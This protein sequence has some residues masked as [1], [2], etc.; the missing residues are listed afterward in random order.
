[1]NVL[2]WTTKHGP[3]PQ[4]VSCGHHAG[5][6]VLLTDADKGRERLALQV[7]CFKAE[8]DLMPVAPTADL[9]FLQ[10]QRLAEDVDLQE[11]MRRLSGMG[12]LTVSLTKAQTTLSKP[13]SGRQWIHSRK[14]QHDEMLQDE[15]ILRSMVAGPKTAISSLRHQADAVQ[16][17][18]L[19]KQQDV[20]QTQERLITQ[21]AAMDT[22]PNASLFVTGP[23]P[24][25]GF[26]KLRTDHAAVT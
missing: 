24:P 2:G 4:G 20:A 14:A 7:Q 11:Q 3:W 10:A 17:D 15:Q 5:L 1:M 16:C 26:A 8:W 25:F 21:A 18:L 6:F 13:T 12:Q 9:S 22:S 19:I 23:W